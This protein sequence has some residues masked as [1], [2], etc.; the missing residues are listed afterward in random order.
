MG[1]RFFARKIRRLRPGLNPRTWV[2]KASTLPL[3]HRS[4]FIF[5]IICH[6]IL[7]R[8][9][10]ISDKTCRENQNTFS[11]QL[12][13]RK[14]CH[15]SDKEEKYIGVRQATDDN[16]IWRMCFACWTTKATHALR[17]YHTYCFQ[18]Q[19]YLAHAPQYYIIQIWPVLY[20]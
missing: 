17:I 16:V 3:D 20:Y 8:M 2:P 14:S 6:S 10:N 4:R 18:R 19:R 12:L 11:I 9:R 15:L 7:L 5:I 13:F 1:Q